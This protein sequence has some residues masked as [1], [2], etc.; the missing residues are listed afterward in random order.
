M[1]CM[2]SMSNIIVPCNAAFVLI[3]LQTMYNKA[4]IIRFG[5][6][7]IRNN[8]GQ[9]LNFPS[10]LSMVFVNKTYPL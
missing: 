8:Q 7:D 1:Q 5:S 4:I 2:I 9:G 10:Y 3:F 6:C